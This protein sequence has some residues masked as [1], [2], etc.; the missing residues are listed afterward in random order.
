YLPELP[1]LPHHPK[2]PSPLQY[3]I[4]QNKE[5]KYQAISVEYISKTWVETLLNQRSGNIFLDN[6][7]IS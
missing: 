1:H 2:I 7:G 5:N 3:W 4:K 6:K